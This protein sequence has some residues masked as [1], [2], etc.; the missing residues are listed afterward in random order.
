MIGAMAN[1]D[2]SYIQARSTNGVESC[3]FDG[4]ALYRD[5]YRGFATAPHVH[6]GIQIIVPLAGRMHFFADGEDHLMGPEGACLVLPETRHGFNCIDGHQSFLALFA[7]PAWLDTLNQ[8]LSGIKL[9]ESGAVIAKDAGIWLQGQQIA[10][11]LRAKNVGTQRLLATCMDQLGIYF[12]RAMENATPAKATS[13]EPRVLRAIDMILKRYAEELTT[14][15]LAQELA[16]SPRQFERCFKQEIGSTPRQFLI[17]VRLG[18]GAEM[19][20]TT[21]KSVSEIALAVGFKNPSHFS[22]AFQRSTELTP[23][24][25]RQGRKGKK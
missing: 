8:G 13:R 3:E 12:L 23:S 25:F 9:P 18:A 21:D 19:L 4:F 1:Q 7:P 10:A 15:L 20:R 22:E 6:E 24:A 11:E 2:F 5:E 14:E 16:L 17:D